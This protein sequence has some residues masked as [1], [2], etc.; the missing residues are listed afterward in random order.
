MEITDGGQVDGLL[1]RSGAG[2]G[3][4]TCVAPVIGVLQ[5]FDEQVDAGQVALRRDPAPNNGHNREK[6][7]RRSQWWW[8]LSWFVRRGFW[9]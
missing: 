7:G 1:Q 2:V 9:R 8:E 3:G 6:R 5:A 4:S